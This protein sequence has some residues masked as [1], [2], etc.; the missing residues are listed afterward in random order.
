MPQFI[1]GRDETVNE[2]VQALLASFSW[3]FTG[4]GGMGK[5]T[6]AA[7]TMRH[8]DIQARFQSRCFIVYCH[9]LDYTDF[10]R[11]GI[12]LRLAKAV[13]KS[14]YSPVPPPEASITDPPSAQLAQSLSNIRSRV[15]LAPTLLL[16]DNMETATH[17]AESGVEDIFTRL[18]AMPN[19]NILGTS[20]NRSLQP[21]NTVS[22]E[23][24]PLGLDDSWALFRDYFRGTVAPEQQQAVE[25]ILQAMDGHALSI[26]L[27]AAYARTNTLAAA[28]TGWP[29]YG[30]T[31]LRNGDTNDKHGSL[32]ASVELSLDGID[33]AR[34]SPTRALLLFLSSKMGGF[35]AVPER[36]IEVF[37]QQ[38]PQAIRK[39]LRLSLV[40][41]RK[42]DARNRLPAYH[43]LQPISQYMQETYGSLA[44]QNEADACRS[45]MAVLSCLCTALAGPFVHSPIA[46]LSRP[47][48]CLN[49]CICKT[50]A[51]KSA[52][53]FERHYL[54]NREAYLMIQTEAVEHILF[55]T[56]NHFDS[57]QISAWEFC[58]SLLNLA[59]ANAGRRLASPSDA[60]AAGRKLSDLLM[61]LALHAHL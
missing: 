42:P 49:L 2:A 18:A 45:Y 8:P 1:A 16:L 11:V 59:F 58:G 50:R 57:G 52:S 15:A 46:G 47:S 29:V 43:V 30:T 41:I 21:R 28:I 37:S 54:D 3:I 23:L 10:S 24:P 34:D 4:V 17:F 7:A 5:T 13:L 25:P 31:L 6:V 39:L 33:P 32:A 56:R 60:P 22:S 35:P 40:L 27:I 51:E 36:T 20:R 26:V 9:E 38:D 14:L 55:K 48:D 61:E 19:L 53:S 44:Q 12:Q